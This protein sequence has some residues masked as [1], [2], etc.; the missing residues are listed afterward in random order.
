ML[1][2]FPTPDACESMSGSIFLSNPM[3]SANDDI[4]IHGIYQIVDRPRDGLLGHS[5]KSALG[6]VPAG[7][8]ARS[9]ESPS[10]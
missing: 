1:H 4:N 3:K 9:L 5:A 2:P 10:V 8:G 6:L 7:V